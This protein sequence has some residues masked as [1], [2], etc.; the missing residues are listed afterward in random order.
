LRGDDP[1]LLA[2]P[3]LWIREDATTPEKRQAIARHVASR[4]ADVPEPPPDPQAPRM[5]GAIPPERRRIAL[6]GYHDKAGRNFDAGSIH[7]A[8]DPFVRANPS[9]FAEPRRHE[10]HVPNPRPRSSPAAVGW[11]TIRP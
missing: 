3:Q 8:K 2:A 9:L 4:R 6:K 7:D 5:L 10:H 11:A 1:N